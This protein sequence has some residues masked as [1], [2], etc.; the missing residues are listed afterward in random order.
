[1]IRTKLIRGCAWLFWKL[2]I[3]MEKDYVNLVLLLK[4][5]EARLRV[6]EVPPAESC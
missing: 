3:I 6:K 4:A 5:V 2:H 1:M